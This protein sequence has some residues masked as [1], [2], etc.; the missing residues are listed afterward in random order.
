MFS[1]PSSLNL[2]QVIQIMFLIFCGDTFLLVYHYLIPY[3]N[4]GT[5]ASS[6]KLH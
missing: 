2:G 4:T 6:Q 3:L 5:S 1:L